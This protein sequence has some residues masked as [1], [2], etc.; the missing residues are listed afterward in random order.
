MFGFWNFPIEILIDMGDMMVNHYDHATG[1]RCMI[2]YPLGAC[3]AEKLPQAGDLFDAEFMRVWVFEESTLRP[4]GKDKLVATVRFNLA[5]SANEVNG[6]RPTEV[7][8]KFTGQETC[9]Q[10]VEIVANMCTH[11]LSM[12][13]TRGQNCIGLLT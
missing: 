11:V 12:S 3:V 4:Y 5:D 6:V 2:G 1:L 13:F 8:W 9:M 7:P 10:F